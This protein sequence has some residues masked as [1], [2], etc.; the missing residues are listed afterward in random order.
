[1]SRIATITKPILFASVLA[2]AFAIAAPVSFDS[3]SGLTVKQ[4]FA[5]NGADD[6]AGHDKGDKRGRKADGPGHR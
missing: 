6:P 2:T 1:M 5:K 3:H 4:A